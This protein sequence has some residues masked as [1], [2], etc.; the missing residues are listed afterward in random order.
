MV[1]TSLKASELRNLLCPAKVMVIGDLM[2]DAY[3]FGFVKR[4]SPEAPVPILQVE[5]E[6]K[7][8]G[9]SAMHY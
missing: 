9:V 6:E 3:T 8:A 5:K 4:I 1:K 2:L 7:R